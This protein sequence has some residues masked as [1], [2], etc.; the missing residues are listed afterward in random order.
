MTERALHPLLFAH[1]DGITV[2]DVADELELP[3]DEAK[4]LL[5][6][7]T[8]AGAITVT[9]AEDGSLLYHTSRRVRPSHSVQSALGELQTRQRESRAVLVAV[10]A[11]STFA[12]LVVALAWRSAPMSAPPI[13]VTPVPAPLERAAAARAQEQQRIWREERARLVT[14]HPRLETAS[15]TC[16]EAWGQGATCYTGD[17]MVTR[18]QHANEGARVTLRVTELDA[19]L[20]T[21]SP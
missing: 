6:A 15:T 3:R 7:E 13:P 4:A 18:N 14:A 1:P 10:V 8:T 11:L 17:R 19:L 9:C 20:A 12:A 21:Q 5:A 16:A 2:D